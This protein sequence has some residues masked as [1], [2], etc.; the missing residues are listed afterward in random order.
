MTRRFRS[1]GR[2]ATLSL[3]LGFAAC[4]DTTAPVEPPV[5][6]PPPPPAVVPPAVVID[7]Q[8]ARVAW[9]FVEQNTTAATGLANAIYP[10]QYVT[11]WDIASLIAAAYSAHAIGIVSDSTYD[12]RIRTILGTLARVPLFEGAAFN[13][14]YDSHT[15][16]MISSDRQLSSVGY[17][18]SATDIGRLL[19]WLR[20]L[21]LNEP[22]YATL[23]SSI[24]DRL[25]ISRLIRNGTLQGRD[26]DPATGIARDYAE[27]GLGYEQYASAGYALWGHRPSAS[28][29]PSAH[30]SRVDIYGVSV[31]V[32]ARGN[33]RITSEPYVMM[34]LETGFWSPTLREQAVAVLAAQEARWRSTGMLTMVSEDAL[35]DPPYYFYY[36]SLFHNGRAFVVEGPEDGSYIE[37]PRWVSTKM[38]YGW[39]ALFPSP[40]TRLVLDAVQ[41]AAVPGRGWSAGVY[42]TSRLPASEQGLNTAA[43]VLE[44]LLYQSRRSQPFLSQPIQ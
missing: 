22:Q 2:M 5:E 19:I 40:Y 24:V 14:S 43:L 15:A 37:A 10:F 34:G 4:R 36:Y 35:P 41:P 8:A 38:A 11:A 20:I 23:A 6:T 42:E 13:K 39:N 12:A 32:D 9:S 27:T 25:D 31:T 44:S 18:W 16:Q 28:L 29:D 33:S 1:I 26:L 30:T 17:G 3:V 7:T 21:A